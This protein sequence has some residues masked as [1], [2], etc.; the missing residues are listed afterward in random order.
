MDRR[1]IIVLVLCFVL[2]M[3]WPVMIQTIW[4]SR[5]VQRTNTVSG[6]T[7]G[8]PTRPDQTTGAPPAQAE[9][10]L[11]PPLT[12]PATLVAPGTHE[13]TEIL[14]NKEAR[15]TFT[16]HGGGLKLV[17]LKEYQQTITCGK[18][19]SGGANVAKLNSGASLPI[20]TLLGSDDLVGDGLFK[21][22]RTAGGVRA[23]QE[24]PQG[25]HLVKEF[26][27]ASNYLM[28]V[29][30][31]LQNRSNK[32]LSVSAQ[33][34]VIGT[35]TPL[36][37]A[38][39]SL[40]MGVYYYDGED[41]EH[42]GEGWFANKTLGCFPG[43]PRDRFESKP[44]KVLWAAAHNQFFTIT[45]MPKEPAVQMVAIRTKLPAPGAEVLASDKK[46][47]RDPFG[48]QA[49]LIY[50]ATILETNQVLEQEFFI[51]AGPKEYNR[52]ARIGDQFNNNADLVMG[53]DT[54]FGG[55]FIGFFA[56]MLLLSMNGLS[57]LGLSYAL[58][59]IVI[60]II[61]KILFWPLTQASTRSM[62]RMAALQPH[63]KAIQEKYK[64]EPRKMQQK[65]LELYKEHKVN[66]MGGCLPMLLQ[67][68]VFF[69]FFKMIQTAIELRGARFLWAC[70]LSKPDT[71]LV[72]PGFGF[73]LNPLPLIMG[74]TM[75]W[76]ARLTPPS[77]GMDPMQQKIMRYMPLIFLFILYNFSAG[78]TLYWTVQNLLTIAQMKLTRAKD[79]KAV[80]VSKGPSSA[81]PAAPP[82][83]KKR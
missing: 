54:G 73:P 71:I 37:P 63:M 6:I 22:T 25:L 38:D 2:I 60:T 11:E 51:Y 8:I 70:D 48:F 74:A 66:P 75:L 14:E 5:P 27:P 34:W 82:R 17:E 79:E 43:T 42:V 64:E 67:I 40:F 36:G 10:V 31:R 47:V 62:K 72:I 57:S 45:A 20:L 55:R 61:I 32:P 65:M 53:F 30:A 35:A 68:P 21:L 39:E 83:K 9:R 28:R 1:S 58:A 15:Y 23:E 77:P 13:R 49:R 44:G 19:R 46:A 56:K 80:V 12:E 26:E 4:P 76:Q 41:A 69:G 16:S 3:L 18:T 7:G 24:L 81:P 50:P 52:L 29:V 59:I 78:L 33:H